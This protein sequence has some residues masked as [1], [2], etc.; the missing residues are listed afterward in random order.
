MRSFLLPVIVLG[1]AACK[2]EVKKE[3][4]YV[5]IDREVIKEVQVPVAA[6]PATPG[7][8][9]T[10]GQTPGPQTPAPSPVVVDP[11]ETAESVAISGTLALS[12]AAEAGRPATERGR[13]IDRSAPVQGRNMV[14]TETYFLKCVNT[15]VDDEKSCLVSVTGGAFSMN[16]PFKNEPFGCFIM[17]GAD[18]ENLSIKGIITSEDMVMGSETT[19]A[20]MDIVFDPKTGAA[21]ATVQQK[22]GEKEVDPSTIQKSVPPALKSLAIE[23]GLYRFCF[24]GIANGDDAAKGIFSAHGD[25]CNG[26]QQNFFMNFT[27]ATDDKFP[28]LELWKSASDRE[29]CLVS[30]TETYHLSDGVNSLSF[31]KDNVKY[32]GASGLLQKIIDNK[33]AP[34]DYLTYYATAQSRIQ[35]DPWKDELKT[36]YPSGQFPNGI[37]SGFI[38]DMI[39]SWKTGKVEKVDGI[40]Q[41]TNVTWVKDNIQWYAPSDWCV[42]WHKSSGDQRAELETGFQIDCKAH[43]ENS[44]GD[45]F[46]AGQQ[47]VRSFLDK[48]S[49]AR[50]QSSDARFDGLKL[51]FNALV[52]AIGDEATMLNVANDYS[53]VSTYDTK[54]MAFARDWAEIDWDWNRRTALECMAKDVT[55]APSTCQNLQ[56][57]DASFPTLRKLFWHILRSPNPW[58]GQGG[59][60]ST[61]AQFIKNE[62]CRMNGGQI[63]LSRVPTGSGSALETFFSNVGYNEERRIVFSQSL[64]ANQRKQLWADLFDAILDN[65]FVHGCDVTRIQDMKQQIANFDPAFSNDNYNPI[66]QTLEWFGWQLDERRQ[67]AA[68][69]AIDLQDA[70]DNGESPFASGLSD[71]TRNSRAGT[72]LPALATQLAEIG[73]QFPSRYFHFLFELCYTLDAGTINGL[74]FEGNPITITCGGAIPDPI[75]PYAWNCRPEDLQNDPDNACKWP[76]YHDSGRPAFEALSDIVSRIS[77]E[78]AHSSFYNDPVFKEK[79]TDIMTHSNCLPDA[80]LEH[81]PSLEGSELAFKV[82]VRAPVNRKMSGSMTIDLARDETKTPKF[83]VR[84]ERLEKFDGGLDS[85]AC[86]WGERKVLGSIRYNSDMKKLSGV[87]TQGWIDT[88]HGE[89]S[90]SDNVWYESISATKK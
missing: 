62:M 24:Q 19:H 51:S 5:Y 57:S 80:S 1:L 60:T 58:A 48:I 4:E 63:D 2:G 43:L 31:T 14:S 46:W 87:M 32:S 59:D 75:K 47:M 76:Q 49:Q 69:D 16:C 37:C 79:M 18:A 36:I 35:N 6:P 65:H 86:Y 73:L 84:E 11:D 9:S 23:S 81:H 64:T 90:G 68:M 28:V 41:C 42:R 3:T 50:H 10:S 45:A 40:E 77:G 30:G 74:T 66:D 38:P 71:A 61:G 89:G 82:T 29:K 85:K 83:L 70:D 54:V 88:C 8:E 27:P 34:D 12:L 67:A 26:Y 33:W 17:V 7:S 13:M 20:K 44:N 55:A 78:R 15:A 52:A 25:T 56:A 39:N 72:D 22:V 53:A 21:S